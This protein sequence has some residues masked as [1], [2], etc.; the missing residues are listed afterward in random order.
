MLSILEHA[1][2]LISRSSMFLFKSPLKNIKSKYNLIKLDENEL[3]QF[4]SEQHNFENVNCLHVSYCCII[5]SYLS[6]SMRK[7]LCTTLAMIVH[8]TR[9][10]DLV[11]VW[12]ALG[13]LIAL[14]YFII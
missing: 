9:S 6:Q 10:R 1:A 3:Y 7:F 2:L 11:C 13:H 4:L 12:I 8:L 14:K 5:V